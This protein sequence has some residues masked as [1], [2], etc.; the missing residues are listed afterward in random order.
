MRGHWFTAAAAA[1]GLGLAYAAGVEVRNF[2]VRQ[3]NVACLPS[4]HA[5][6]RVLHFSDLHLV[7]SQHK[8]IEWIRSLASW[9]P[10][11][12][13]DTG[14]NIAHR[15][16]VPV[17]IDAL[18]D[19][20]DVPG[21][22]VPGSNDYFEPSVRN[23]VRYLLPDNGRRHIDKPQLP[24]PTMHGV[25]ERRGW[26]NLSN[27]VGTLDV[28]GTRFGLAGLDD[29]HLSRDDLSVIADVDTDVDLLV[30]VAH[31]PYLRVLDAF[32]NAGFD[33]TF[34]VHTHG[35]QLCL[36]Y[37][38]ALVTNCD[39]ET[40][41][42]KGLHRHPANSTPLDPDST[43]LH[44]SAGAGTSPYAPVRFFCRP[45]ATLLTLSPTEV[46]RVRTQ[47]KEVVNL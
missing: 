26:L 16:A 42:A 43:W 18:G 3:V 39:L 15:D 37:F 44:V 32:A 23:P 21:V 4:G 46:G 25:F 22:F 9:A 19:L 29:P 6:I 12:V 34:A 11:L 14:D 47:V 38:G 45:E 28:L 13:I 5:P 7:P 20:L 31:A 2:V 27:A 10:D 36:P 17:L 40:G 41:R 8:K 24:W 30:G 1:G 33:F 35:G